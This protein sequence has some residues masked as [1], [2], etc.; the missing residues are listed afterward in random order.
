MSRVQET[1]DRTALCGAEIPF[2]DL[3]LDRLRPPNPP[4]CA[5]LEPLM[6]PDRLRASLLSAPR[7]FPGAR[8]PADREVS[9]ISSLIAGFAALLPP[10]HRRGA[11]STWEWRA[12]SPGSGESTAWS[13]SGATGRATPV[14]ELLDQVERALSGVAAQNGCPQGAFQVMV[15]VHPS[16]PFDGYGPTRTGDAPHGCDL[17]LEFGDHPEGLQVG[18]RYSANL[19]DPATAVRMAGHLGVLLDAAAS[20]PDLRLNHLPLLTEA[21]S[22]RLL[23]EW[24]DPREYAQEKGLHQLFEEQVRRSPKAVALTFEGETTRRAQRPQQ[25]DRPRPGAAGREAAP[26]AWRR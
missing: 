21:E 19:F 12:G 13:A 15:R 9:I 4:R 10:L 24:N 17:A 5:S 20:N 16:V 23:V 25:P 11:V 8:D 6:L 26:G 22:Y 2:L 1:A 14:L 7:R 18:L 3:P